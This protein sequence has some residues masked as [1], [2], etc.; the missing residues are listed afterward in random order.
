MNTATIDAFGDGQRRLLTL[1]LETKNG[2]SADELAERL[3]VSRSAVHQHLTALERDE[4]VAKK[5][6]AP[7]GG[8][9]GYAWTLTDGGVHLFP[10]QYALL[11]SLLVGALKETLSSDE[12]VRALRVLGEKLAGEHAERLRG[13]TRA[14]Q[15]EIVAQLMRE[16]G[17]HARAVPDKGASLPMID[18]RNCVYHHLAA[19]H[20]EVCE[21]DLALLSSLLGGKIEHVEC[22][23]RGGGSCRFRLLEKT[24]GRM[25]SP[26]RAKPKAGLDR[27][28]AAL[29]RGRTPRSV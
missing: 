6:L 24:S 13:K 14:E 5:P 26:G 15:I 23:V 25:A 22:M 19:E 16:L 27:N 10:K 18:A 28:A 8:R 29:G 3:E 11:A 21:L 4:L 1:L 20:P 2:L 7:K 17:Y 12:L 9:P